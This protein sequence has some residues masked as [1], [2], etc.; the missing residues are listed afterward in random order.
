MERILIVKDL[1]VNFYTYEGI[2]KALDEVNFDLIRGETL[3]IVGETGCGKSVTVQTILRL[4][5]MPPGRI[6][7]GKILFLMEDNS[8]GGSATNKKYVN[9]L[10]LTESQMCKIRGNRISMVFQEPMT[11]LN[12]TFTVGEQIGKSFLLHQKEELYEG[13]LKRIEV[14]IGKASKELEQNR[15]TLRGLVKRCK[16][17]GKLILYRWHRKIYEDMLNNSEKFY[18][19]LMSQIPI[20]KSYNKWLKEEVRNRTIELLRKVK[21]P[22][23]AEIVNR[24][25]H[26]LSGGMRQR[27]L[28]AIATSCNPNI[29]I[30]DEPTTALDV[31][32]EVAILELINELKASIGCSVIYITH[33]LAIIAEICDRV[34][35][36]Y[37][38]VI[39]ETGS[40]EAI[41]N[42]PLHPYTRGLIKTIPKLH[43][44]REELDVI[45]GTV[46]NLVN[47]PT[48]CRFHP[49][50]PFA[51]KICG[52][53]KPNLKEFKKGH[54]VACHLY[55][56][57]SEV[58]ANE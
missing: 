54:Y 56:K 39:V 58:H 36:M 1:A 24:Y 44:K 37:A 20:V 11:A 45:P 42:E 19:K 29:L 57:S 6:E 30:A 31:T 25:P 14:E 10:E 32:T 18:H 33:D 43:E 9:L 28:I 46:P 55:K 12:P 7:G 8:S 3:G 51:R 22:T 23:P 35:V 38:G 15:I 16:L 2:V 40:V 4:I 49:R 26:E 41:F 13:V 34:A 27:V 17:K 52:E 48:G 5:S 53:V 50:C 47:P 21:I